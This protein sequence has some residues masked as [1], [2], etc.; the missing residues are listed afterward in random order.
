MLVTLKAILK[1]AEAKECAVGALTH[2][3]L[4]A[5]RR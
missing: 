2:R 3:T 1:I 4:Q 5:C